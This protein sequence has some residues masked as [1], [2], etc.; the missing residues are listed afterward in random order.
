MTK[1]TVENLDLCKLPNLKLIFILQPLH[2]ALLS[3]MEA[4]F[5]KAQ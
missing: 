3:L 1:I 5:E 4:I 2:C